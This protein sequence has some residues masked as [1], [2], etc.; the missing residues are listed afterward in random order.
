MQHSNGQNSFNTKN[1]TMTTIQEHNYGGLTDGWNTTCQTCLECCKNPGMILKREIKQRGLS[2][3][4]LAESMGIA[5]TVLNEILNGR[6]PLTE[7]MALRFEASLGVDVE[8]LM[9]M[10]T[11]INLQRMREGAMLKQPFGSVQAVERG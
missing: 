9:I 7:K 11:K 3:Y 4:R 10:Q 1:Q 8:P 5:K 2:Q 6:R